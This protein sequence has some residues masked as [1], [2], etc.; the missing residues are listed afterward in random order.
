MCC[1]IVVEGKNYRCGDLIPVRSAYNCRELVKPG[2]GRWTGFARSETAE[3][4]WGDSFAIEL[5]IPAESF[6]EYNRPASKKAGTKVETEANLSR[7]QVIYALGQRKTGGIR[8]LT[9]EASV[10]EKIRFGHHRMPLTGPIRFQFPTPETS[11]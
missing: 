9:R 8:I 10:T 1:K 11:S 3:A 5:D 6:A 7:G 2:K 4:T